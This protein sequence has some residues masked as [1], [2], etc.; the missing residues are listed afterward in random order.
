FLLFRILAKLLSVFFGSHGRCEHEISGHTRDRIHFYSKM[1]QEKT[2]KY[3]SG[4]YSDPYFLIDGQYDFT[5]LEIVQI[6]GIRPYLSYRVHGCRHPEIPCSQHVILTRVSQQP[7]EL[8]THCLYFQEFIVTLDVG[9]DVIPGNQTTQQK[10]DQDNRRNSSPYQF[11]C[12]VVVDKGSTL[13]L[14]LP[15]FPG[16]EEQ[17]KLCDDKDD[18]CKE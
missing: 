18:P 1:R 2:V 16:K 9:H 4:Q 14:F 6:F 15:I 10:D 12:Q 8:H 7:V 17:H 11:Q 3:F 5:G 13:A